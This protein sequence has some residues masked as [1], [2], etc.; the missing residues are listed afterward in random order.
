MVTNIYYY[1]LQAPVSTP[2]HPAKIVPARTR[3]V[4][5]ARMRSKEMSTDP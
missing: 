5:F 1:Y 4:V 2:N 3:C